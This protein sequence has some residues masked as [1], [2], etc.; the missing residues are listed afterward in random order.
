MGTERD[1]KDA[2]D[3][4]YTERERHLLYH[5]DHTRRGAR[6][7]G[8]YVRQDEIDERRL[9]APLAEPIDE[10]REDVRDR[11]GVQ[12]RVIH[13]GHEGYESG[14]H[15]DGAELQNLP[16]QTRREAR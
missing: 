4:G 11:R 10:Q 14:D 7:L 3:H 5:R 6:V 13:D 2:A 15:E 8:W 9:Q 12:R 16:P 1:R